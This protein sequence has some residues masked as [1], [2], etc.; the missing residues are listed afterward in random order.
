MAPLFRLGLVVAVVAA[1]GDATTEASGPSSPSAPSNATRPAAPTAA[2]EDGLATGTADLGGGG[3]PGI[4]VDAVRVPGAAHPIALSAVAAPTVTGGLAALATIQGGAAIAFSFAPDNAAQIVAVDAEGVLRARY[5]IPDGVGQ[6]LVRGFD[7]DGDSVPDFGLIGVAPM[8]S[9][10]CGA[11]QRRTLRVFAGR[12]AAASASPTL[13]LSTAVDDPCISLNGAAKT[14]YV[15]LAAL[16]IHFGAPG[17]LAVAPQYSDQ[18]SLFRWTGA[19]VEALAVITPNTSAYDTTYPGLVSPAP[20]K[21]DG[22]A[23][24]EYTQP[25]SGLLRTKDGNLAYD[26]VTSA[27]VLHYAWSPLGTSGVTALVSDRTYLGR[28]HLVGRN[29]GLLQVDERAQLLTRVGG[30]TVAEVTW[31][32]RG[33]TTAVQLADADIAGALERGLWTYDLANDSYVAKRFLGYAYDQQGRGSYNK[34]VLHPARSHLPTAEGPRLV[35]S[36]FQMDIPADDGPATG[37][38]WEVHLTNPRGVDSAIVVPD[39]IVW[40]LIPRGEGIVDVLASDIDATPVYVPEYTDPS[41]NT[42]AGWVKARYYPK[43]ETKILRWTAASGGWS[44]VTTLPGLPYLDVPLP[45]RFDVLSTAG[46][47]FGAI[48]ALVGRQ[49]A[50]WM[51]RANGAIEPEPVTW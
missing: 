46:F 32:L 25:F 36:V 42:I 22:S 44:T 19:G 33:S 16:S 28:E 18:G 27:R 30:V 26:A 40:D 15:G 49:P 6:E 29:Y 7:F 47:R 20:Q 23:F 5:E 45:N 4:G 12:K 48:V 31:Q 11:Q 37:G 38:H 51:K 13:L 1:C 3:T 21:T 8:T 34:R 24:V 9:P 41:A 35:A 50:L 17:F 43:Q 2:V 39:M 14:P 10:T